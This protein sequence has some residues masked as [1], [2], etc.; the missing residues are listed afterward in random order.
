MLLTGVCLRRRKACEHFLMCVCLG[1]P[2]KT[3]ETGL[4]NGVGAVH[5]TPVMFFNCWSR[6][7]QP[8]ANESFFICFHCPLFIPSCHSLNLGHGGGFA[9]VLGSG[10][11]SLGARED[12]KG[13]LPP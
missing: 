10:A 4:W 8:S 7:Q 1:H 3:P 11:S 6:E 9:A 12:G 2:W 13:E 5:S